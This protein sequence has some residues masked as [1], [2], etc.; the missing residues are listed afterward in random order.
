MEQKRNL[1]NELIKQADELRYLPATTEID[2]VVDALVKS[3]RNAEAVK[4][5]LGLTGQP[6]MTLQAVA[7]RMGVTRERI[8][9]I[10][11]RFRR[12]LRIRRR[13]W[14]PALNRALRTLRDAAPIAW[15]EADELLRQERLIDDRSGVRAV[16]DAAR[17]FGLRVPFDV[18]DGVIFPRGSAEAATATPPMARRLVSHWGATT[19]E[20]LRAVLAEQQR[21][22]IDSDTARQVLAVV[23]GRA[24][25]DE[26]QDWFWI[27][28]TSRNR[29]LN[30]IEKIMS[31]AGS[32]DI[33]DLRNGV[34][35]HHR[36]KGFR[37]PREVLARLCVDSGLYRREGDRIIG[38]AD[39]PDW[40]EA[41]GGNEA[42]LTEILF[43]HGPAMRRDELERRA[44]DE[45]GMNRSSFY[46]YL[47]YSPIL[48]R[49]APGVYGLRGAPVSAATIKALIPQQTRQ[50][51]LQD[52]GW[53]SE[54]QV[55]IAYRVSP[56][57]ATS[58]VLGVP[59]NLDDLLRGSY[60]LLAEDTRN[61]GTLVVDDNIWGVSPFYRRWGVE[62]GDYL[63]VQFDLAEKSAVLTAGEEEILLRFQEAE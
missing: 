18:S 54:G 38:G 30:Q 42:A 8:R 28:G 51:V 41:L 23:P 1:I 62:A 36:M 46:V 29:L 24:W 39:L 9:Q 3:E 35:R 59:A 58:G 19:V 45:G 4:L 20:E 56:A 48:E 34:G 11:A 57:G 15:A 60:R 33:G 55:W 27:K 16:V 10:E 37:P 50:Q 32:I 31:V 5:R 13:P 21:G 47:S 63:V 49:F 43:D 26:T 2:Q 22:E 40:R 12:E 7:D 53:T 44:V 61:V 6:A 14:T 52:H 17:L 25:L